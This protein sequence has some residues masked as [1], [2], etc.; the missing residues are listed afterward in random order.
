M[1][2]MEPDD[3]TRVEVELG[4]QPSALWKKLEEL[5]LND[6]PTYSSYDKTTAKSS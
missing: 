1:N 5:G 2:N 6:E 4:M 3:L